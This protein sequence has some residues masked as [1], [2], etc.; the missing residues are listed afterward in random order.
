MKILLGSL[1]IEPESRM[2]D[3]PNAAYSMGLTYLYSSLEQ[4]GHEV[5]LCFLNNFA[6]DSF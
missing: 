6:A 3:S 4:A 5:K 2:Q 1:S